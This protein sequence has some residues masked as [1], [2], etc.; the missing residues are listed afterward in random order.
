[1]GQ[2]VKDNLTGF[3]GIATGV[4]TF[5]SGCLRVEVT[6]DSLKDG[7]PIDPEVFDEQRLIGQSKATTGGPLDGPPAFRAPK[8]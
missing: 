5:L 2:K 4:F 7:K 8:R 3:S 1:M 6:P